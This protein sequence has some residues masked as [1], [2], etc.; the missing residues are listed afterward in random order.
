MIFEV[1]P[2]HE[3]HRPS[4]SLP[5]LVADKKCLARD[6]MNV[7]IQVACVVIPDCRWDPI[8][9]STEWHK[10]VDNLWN[11]EAHKNTPTSYPDIR[12]LYVRGPVQQSY[13]QSVIGQY[14]TYILSL[15]ISPIKSANNK[16][17]PKCG[18]K[19]K[20]AITNHIIQ[21]LSEAYNY[22]C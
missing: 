1:E 17:K 20:I 8:D 15:S 7:A 14:L 3:V 16:S 21:L 9:K 10:Y 12:H 4:H 18:C 19:M 13:N 11:A 22:F 5:Y 2:V 6:E